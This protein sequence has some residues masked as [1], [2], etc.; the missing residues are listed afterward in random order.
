M[1]KSRKRVETEVA[2]YWLTHDSAEE[3]DWAAPRIGLEFDPAVE[4]PTQP[5]TVRL[6]RLKRERASG[7]IARGPERPGDA[8]DVRA[9]AL[10]AQ[11]IAGEGIARGARPFSE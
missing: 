5:V 6:P 10:P 7:S 4:R 9:P 1:R 2:D 8:I 3:I 11:P